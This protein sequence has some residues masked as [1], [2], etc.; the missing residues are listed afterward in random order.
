MSVQRRTRPLVGY[1]LDN[2]L[3]NLSPQPVVAQRAPTTLDTAEIGT[4]WLDQSNSVVYLLVDVSGGVS[5]WEPNYAVTTLFVESSIVFNE[6]PAILS[7]DGDP[8]VA[9][10]IAPINS[11]YIQADGATAVTRLWVT[12]DGAGTWAFF[13]A[14]A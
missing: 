5:D 6:G 4:L 14:S 7:G 10:V 8:N 11:L 12:T 1:G 2:A 13:T 3:Q 9:P